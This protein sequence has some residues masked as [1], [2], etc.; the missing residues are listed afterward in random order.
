MYIIII[1]IIIIS[2]TTINIIIIIIFIL[3]AEAWITIWLWS[4]RLFCC[5]V[6]FDVLILSFIDAILR[7][8]CSDF[9]PILEMN[10]KSSILILFIRVYNVLL[11]CVC[12]RV[13]KWWARETELVWKFLLTANHI[14]KDN[15]KY[16]DEQGKCHG[17]AAA[18]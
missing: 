13:I 6:G 3:F 7:G 9:P 1:I 2:T 16:G 15:Y 14:H 11:L 10:R 5:S 8:T 12:E 4:L 17:V 18:H